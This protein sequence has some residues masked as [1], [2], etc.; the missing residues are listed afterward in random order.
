M[1]RRHRRIPEYI[2]YFSEDRLIEFLQIYQNLGLNKDWELVD[3]D[4]VVIMTSTK[5]RITSEYR[6]NT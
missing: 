1:E 3:D 2:L 6:K 5:E 4:G